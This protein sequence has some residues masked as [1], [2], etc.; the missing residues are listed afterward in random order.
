MKHYGEK[1]FASCGRFFLLLSV[2]FRVTRL[3]EFSPIGRIFANWAIYFFGQFFEN[4]NSIQKLFSKVEVMYLLI[5][6]KNGLG[7]FC[8]NSFGHP[9]SSPEIVFKRVLMSTGGST[10]SV[11]SSSGD[12]KLFGGVEIKELE[13]TNT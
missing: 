3:G 9:G 7:D 12:F 10:L 1:V 4:Y 2:P 8:T 11:R 13:C 5:L 6:T